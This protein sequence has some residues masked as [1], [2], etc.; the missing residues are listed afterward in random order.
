VWDR[1]GDV[2]PGIASPDDAFGGAVSGALASGVGGVGFRSDV[3]PVVVYASDAPFRDPELSSASPGGCLF[4]AGAGAARASA[5]EQG[6][7]LLGVA[8]SD[9]AFAQ[10]SAFA[11]NGGWV[12]DLDGD[13]STSEP[14]VARSNGTDDVSALVVDMLRAA[15]TNSTFREVVLVVDADPAG[16]VRSV[17][18]PAHYDTPAGTVLPFEVAVGGTL[19]PVLGG[20]QEVRVSLVADGRWLL[21]RRSLWVVPNGT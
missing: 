6:A 4:D 5:L 1:L 9:A 12:A 3:L 10:M 15:L 8:T 18:P 19:S 11:N 16:L 20:G 21:E 14:L 2:R 17:T 13:A 7:L